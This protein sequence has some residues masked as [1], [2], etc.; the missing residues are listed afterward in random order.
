MVAIQVTEG[1]EPK[2]S[3]AVTLEVIDGYECGGVTASGTTIENGTVPDIQF[4]G[5][6]Y[7]ENCTATIRVTA[8]QRR[9]MRS[10]R[11]SQSRSPHLSTPP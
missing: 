8:T 4:I 6:L 2:E 5:G 10:Q 9:P 3:V 1:G 7:V 11:R